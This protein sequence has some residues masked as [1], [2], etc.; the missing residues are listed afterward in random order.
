MLQMR[1]APGTQKAGTKGN[2]LNTRVACYITHVKNNS[3]GKAGSYSGSKK[4]QNE[5]SCVCHVAVSMTACSSW[6]RC[7]MFAS[8][9]N[10]NEARFGA[11]RTQRA[12]VALHAH[13]DLF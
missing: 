1:P 3:C 2:A 9:L 7:L 12:Q 5:L 11:D 13:D 6:H 8:S 4:T 10:P